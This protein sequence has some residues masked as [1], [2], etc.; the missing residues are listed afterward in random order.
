MKS[1]INRFLSQ[2]VRFVSKVKLPSEN[3]HVVKLKKWIFNANSVIEYT[4][5]HKWLKNAY[6][7]NLEYEDDEWDGVI[8][9]KW[10][11]RPKCMVT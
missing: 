4:C 9:D 8:K 2:V 1:L 7:F 5:M 10:S 6:I 3:V 11:Q